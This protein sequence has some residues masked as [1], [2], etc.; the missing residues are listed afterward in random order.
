MGPNSLKNLYRTLMLLCVAFVLLFPKISPCANEDFMSYT[1]FFKG[2]SWS[3]KTSDGLTEKITV[4]EYAKISDIQTIVLESNLSGKTTFVFTKDGLFR[5]KA[6]AEANKTILYSNGLQLLK[7]PLSK[8]SSWKS[9]L[10]TP[11]ELTVE[12]LGKENISTPAGDFKDTLKIGFR[13]S[14]GPLYDG[15]IWFAKDIGIV[16]TLENH[17]SKTLTE[18]KITKSDESILNNIGSKSFLSKLTPA[19]LPQKSRKVLGTDDARKG[20]G[21]SVFIRELLRPST[22]FIL[23]VLIV[24]FFFILLLSR[25]SG[26]LKGEVDNLNKESK[27]Y[28]AKT[29]LDMGN[30]QK[31]EKILRKS[32]KGAG[33]FPDS[34]NALGVA[35]KGQKKFKESIDHFRKALSINPQYKEAKVNLAKSLFAVQELKES[36]QILDE[37]L[38]ENPSYSDLHNLMAEIY[39]CTDRNEKAREHLEKAIEI[40]PT[41]ERAQRNLKKIEILTK[42]E[43]NG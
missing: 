33:M 13:L 27:K 40:N 2:S 8:A 29:L 35:L 3:Y 9:D 26:F 6:I 38:I 4:N 19:E 11:H 43:S 16:Q 5:F 20:T 41:Y 31:A 22:L 15:I 14:K 12:V 10:G 36:E 34:L 1:P 18:F 28:L 37:L 25:I 24:F 42:G 7:A 17:L 30:Y 21:L 39:M 32:M 23:A